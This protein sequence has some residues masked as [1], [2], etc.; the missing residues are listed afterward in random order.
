MNS[1]RSQEKKNK[2]RQMHC[3]R[4]NLSIQSLADVTSGT[5]TIQIQGYFRCKILSP[6]GRTD[7]SKIK[8][9]FISILLQCNTPNILHK[10]L[11][12]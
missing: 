9:Q 11:F 6:I 2:L 12:K 5:G 10:L 1:K 4:T 8:A 3:T 7:Y